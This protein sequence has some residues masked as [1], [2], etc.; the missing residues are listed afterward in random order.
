MIHRSRLLLLVTLF[1]ATASSSSGKKKKTVTIVLKGAKAHLRSSGGKQK[2]KKKDC[3]RVMVLKLAASGSTWMWQQLA[4]QR[5]T[6]VIE[7]LFTSSTTLSAAKREAVM[8][9]RLKC[10]DDGEVRGF[11]ISP[12]NSKGVRWDDVATTAQ[13]DVKVVRYMRSN[14][15]KMAISMFRKNEQEVCDGKPNIHHASDC[16]K[17]TTAL[18]IDALRGWLLRAL[19]YRVEYLDKAIETI[20]RRDVDVFDLYYEDLMANKTKS[21]LDLFTFFGRP[22]LLSVETKTKST[23]STGGGK[24]YDEEG[25]ENNNDNATTAATTPAVG[26]VQKKTSNNLRDVISNYDDV[27]TDLIH[28]DTLYD[29]PSC[30]LAAMFVDRGTRAFPDCDVAALAAAMRQYKNTSVAALFPHDAATTVQ[31]IMTLLPPQSSSS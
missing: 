3:A 20:Q 24:K 15:V 12:K 31:P 7:E 16:G 4:M 30:S 21:L 28:L 6:H 26:G 1:L 29:V 5:R 8:R 22:D 25:H 27:L 9:K 10:K 18:P 13:G 17:E 11:T 2:R 23:S 19:G 14:F